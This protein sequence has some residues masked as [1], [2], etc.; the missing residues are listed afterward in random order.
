MPNWKKIVISGS[1]AA[2]NTLNLTTTPNTA[3]DFLTR[4]PNGQI[5]SRTAS[6]VLDDI[7]A[8]QSGSIMPYNNWHLAASNTPNSEEINNGDQVTFIGTNGINAIRDVKDIVLRVD[9]TV[10]RTTG[11]QTLNDTKTFSS[12]IVANGGVTRAGTLDLNT[13]GNN[14]IV[15]ST[16][17]NERLR[18]EGN[19]RTGIG[20][21]TPTHILHIAD[22]PRIDS[23]GNQ[24]EINSF[25]GTEQVF[26]SSE[27]IM[28]EPDVWLRININGTDYIIPAYEE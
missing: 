28:G 9:S 26:G 8:I 1:D 12:A 17:G 15:L 7:N 19:G 25:G 5:S 18:I 22:T 24:P 16:N 3:G 6:Q 20:T 11:N 13:T 4:G 21:S 2:L 27:V 14:D 23:I 10:I